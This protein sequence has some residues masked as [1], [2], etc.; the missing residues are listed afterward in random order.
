MSACGPI[1]TPDELVA[2]RHSF[3]ADKPRRW[4][5]QQLFHPGR[6][7]LDP[8]PDG[9][10]FAVLVAPETGE[11]EK[12]SVHVTMLLNFFDEVKRRIP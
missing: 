9:K 6:S 2:R 1:H 10:R 4:W 11:G 8:A 7:N 3:A 12:G 5:D